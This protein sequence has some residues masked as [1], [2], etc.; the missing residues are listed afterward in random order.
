MAEWHTTPDYI[1]NNWADE[2]LELMGEKLA[3]RKKR[4]RWAIEHG[5]EPEQV[6]E[7]T[8]LSAASNLIEV[9]Y[10]N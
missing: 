8:F 7:E 10:G 2:L 4:E 1:V 6:S 3:E 5:D 9:K